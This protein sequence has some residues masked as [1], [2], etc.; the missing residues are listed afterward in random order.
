M[1]IKEHISKWIHSMQAA[2]YVL[3]VGIRIQIRR[4]CL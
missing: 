1:E 4:I 2:K 3:V